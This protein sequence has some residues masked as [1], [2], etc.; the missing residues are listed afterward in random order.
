MLKK[1][2]SNRCFQENNKRKDLKLSG[3][4]RLVIPSFIMQSFVN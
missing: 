4:A 3:M 1:T 2:C